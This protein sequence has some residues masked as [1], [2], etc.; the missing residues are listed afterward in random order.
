[1]N[2]LQSKPNCRDARLA[3]APAGKEAADARDATQYLVE[4]WHGRRHYV[5][6]WAGRLY[7]VGVEEE[8]FRIQFGASSSRAPTSMQPSCP[9][10]RAQ[11]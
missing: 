10:V 3:V 6:Q 8:Q 4:L 2:V 9:A 11:A 7:F 5:M 1:M